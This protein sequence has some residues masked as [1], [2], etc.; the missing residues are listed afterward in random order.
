MHTPLLPLTRDLVLIGGGH[1]HALV[2]R[3]W[4]MNPLPGARLTVISPGPTAPYSG[5]LPGFVAGHYQRA[6]LDIDLVRLARFADARIIIGS[7]Q[8]IDADRHEVHV[9]DRPPIAFDVA[10]VNVGITSDMPALSGFAEHAIPAK[11]LGA[12]A[13]RWAEY[14]DGSG[15][16]SVAVIGAGVAGAEL[17]MA[18][19]H[20]LRAKARAAQVTLIDSA[21]ALS[22][23]GD[24]AAATIR[25]AMGDLGVDVIEHAA[26]SY[27]ASD[28]VALEDGRQIPAEFVTGAAGA[29]P[30]GWMAQTGLDLH[31]GYIRVNGH[32]QSSDPAIFAA[33]DCAHLTE[34]P[35]PKAGVYAVREAPVLFDNLQAALG[36]GTMRRYVPQ[37]DYLKLISLGG[38]S[39][40]A[41]RFGTSFSGA[42]MWSWKNHIDQ[43]FMNKFRDLPQMPPPALPR[44]HAAGLDEALGDK[45]MCGGCGAKIGRGALQSV[46]NGLPAPLRAD[47]TPLPGDDA[48][49]LTT[50][51]VRQVLTSDHLRGFTN[52]PL[53]MARVAAVHALGDI[54]AM[55]AS[56]QAAT[57]TVILPRMTPEL[58]HRTMAE[59][60][61]TASNVIRD[62]G[63]EIVGGHSSMGDELTIGFTLTGL[64]PNAPITLSGAQAGDALIL[65]K[66]LGSGILMAA[67]MAGQANGAWVM[68]AFRQMVQPQGEAARL[69]TNAH[70]MTDVTGFGLAGHL[71]GMCTASK[72]GATLDLDAVPVMAG[73]QELSAMGVRST[74]FDDN[75]ALVPELPLGGKADLL[76][77]P[78]TAGGLLAAVSPD[79]AMDLCNDLRT[80]GY[81]A[82]IIGR[83][84]DAPGLR[85]QS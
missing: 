9:P 54:W 71:L 4:G 36:A 26:I 33:G 45:P 30:Y 32:L 22:A 25:R 37:K 58:Q 53:L 35:R 75:R 62:A 85:L 81:P 77:D 24:K 68:D 11:P 57:A 70:A 17:A 66:P 23:T 72:C 43:T 21:A 83:L 47:V 41:E 61:T 79:Q 64:C 15:P 1:T 73:A 74:I 18:M 44:H 10:S 14:L 52:D 82:V 27:I 55:G 50:G 31:Q 6:E 49:L 51:G 28:H 29:R 84:S 13:A 42:L 5:M 3:K 2:L 38:K 12:F 39:A 20:A 7:V 63:A 69:L 60:M 56:P 76:F 67:E 48:A 40:L 78:Q 80:A 19:A 34:D 8:G 59:I 16:A 65:T 46:L